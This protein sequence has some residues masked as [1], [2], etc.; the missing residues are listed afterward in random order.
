MIILFLLALPFLLFAVW[1][2][3]KCVPA[4]TSLKD[5]AGYEIGVLIAELLGCGV[6]VYYA[7]ATVGKGVDRAWW[8]TIAFIY[9]FFLF[10]VILLMAALIRWLM[11]RKR[12]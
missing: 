5:R 9:S 3:M 2:Y 10:P 7:Y 8:P 4:A 1:V 11:Y 12:P 6:V